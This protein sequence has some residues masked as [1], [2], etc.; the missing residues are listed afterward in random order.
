MIPE[1]HPETRAE[2]A[3]VRTP[4]ERAPWQRPTLECLPTAAT[5]FGNGSHFDFITT[6]S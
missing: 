1:P 4:D 2:E 5:E 3:P 6:F